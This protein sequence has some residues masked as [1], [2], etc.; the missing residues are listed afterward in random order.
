[1]NVYHT[2]YSSVSCDP[3]VMVTHLTGLNNQTGQMTLV[4]CHTSPLGHY[5]NYRWALNDNSVAIIQ[6][7]YDSTVLERDAIL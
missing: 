5:S 2:F 4:H 3:H 7:T 6:T 1:M